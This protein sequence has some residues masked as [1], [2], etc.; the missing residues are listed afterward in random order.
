MVLRAA[1]L[2]AE[3]L[4]VD[5]SRNP[6]EQ[7]QGHSYQLLQNRGHNFLSFV[8]LQLQDLLENP[9]HVAL[10]QT[11]K[12]ILAGGAAIS[13]GLRAKIKEHHLPVYETYGM[14]ETISHIAVK[15]LRTEDDHFTTLPGVNLEVDEDRCLR[16]SALSTASEWIQ[17]QDVV[18]LLSPTQ[19]RLL[20]RRGNIIN[21]GGVKIQLEEV[22]KIIS[23]RL[24]ANLNFFCYG[25]PDTELGQKL[26]LVVEGA[27]FEINLEDLTFPKYHKPKG[28]LFYPNFART[29]SGKIDKSKTITHD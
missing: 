14:T 21:S 24:P 6:F 8:P 15:D 20:G 26:V 11:A 3:L 17:T 1:E 7:L 5:P 12:A 25:L 9:A 29:A 18:E 28:I 23:A 22:E 16:I 19:F 2:G 27:P 4:A 13:P 10:L